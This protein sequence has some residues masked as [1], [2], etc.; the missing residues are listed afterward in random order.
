MKITKEKFKLAEDII[1]WR[2]A[3]L[4]TELKNCLEEKKVMKRSDFIELNWCR[5]FF[6]M[7]ELIWDE[8]KPRM[9]I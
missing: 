7:K 6:N 3:G 4:E 1:S 5:K 9:I 8:F 2:M